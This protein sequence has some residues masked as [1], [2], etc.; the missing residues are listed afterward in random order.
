[1]V[2]G[3]NTKVAMLHSYLATITQK[4]INF[5]LWVTIHDFFLGLA[6][7]HLASM[8]ESVRP[9]LKRKSTE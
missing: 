5:W 3:V 4:K 2:N 7:A 9:G 1:M 6:I 8:A